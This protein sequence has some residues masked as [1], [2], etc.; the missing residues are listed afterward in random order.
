VFDTPEHKEGAE[1]T[2][3]FIVS[4]L[5]AYG[6]KHLEKII[7]ACM[8]KHVADRLPRLCSRLWAELDILCLVLP[9]STLDDQ[10]TSS[11][12]KGTRKGD[13][14]SI[15]EQAESMSRKCVR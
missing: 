4:E 6:E 1:A 9:E 12:P 13:P 3:D 15:D 8:P 2:I 7:G 14:K 10:Y 5:K 11:V